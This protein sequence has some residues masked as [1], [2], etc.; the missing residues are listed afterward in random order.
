MSEDVT[1]IPVCEQDS[2]TEAA[3]LLREQAQLL[4]RKAAEL[5]RPRERA[6]Q[7]EID[8]D[9]SATYHKNGLLDNDLFIHELHIGAR[10][11]F[12]VTDVPA[13][14]AMQ[15]KITICFW[16]RNKNQLENCVLPSIK[17]LRKGLE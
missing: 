2:I 8:T 10:V 6:I 12:V 15:D 4:L 9:I 17:V 1:K 3:N 5:Q 16:A 14:Y 7:Q 13:F 11:E